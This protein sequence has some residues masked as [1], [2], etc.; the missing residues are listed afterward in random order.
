MLIYVLIGVALWL[1]KSGHILY[2]LFQRDS[3][4]RVIGMG[5]FSD[6]LKWMVLVFIWPVF[7]V[8][9]IVGCLQK[10]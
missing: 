3:S 10:K 6:I 8:A 1:L 5:L 9:L 2:E 7:V 4:C